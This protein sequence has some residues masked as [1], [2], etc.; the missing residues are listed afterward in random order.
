M[1]ITAYCKECKKIDKNNGRY[2]IE[3]KESPFNNDEPD[4]DHFYPY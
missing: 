3:I 4:K 1:K 2:D